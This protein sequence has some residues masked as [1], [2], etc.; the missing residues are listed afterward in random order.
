MP[1]WCENKVTIVGGAA[2]I[3]RLLSWAKSGSFFNNIVPMPPALLENFVH[4]DPR[5]AMNKKLFGYDGWYDWRLAKWGTKWDID[6]NDIIIEEEIDGPNATLK[7]TFLSAWSP[8]I[9]IYHALVA[10]G[11]KVQAAWYEPG[12]MFAGRYMELSDG[13]MVFDYRIPYDVNERK[14]ALPQALLQQF[15]KI[16][17]V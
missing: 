4:G 6:P 8:P 13:P 14:R 2:E 7:M 16:V 5:I 17:E 9:P 10:M 15:P 12:C 11:F 3:N 1:N